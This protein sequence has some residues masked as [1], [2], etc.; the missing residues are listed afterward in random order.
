MIWIRLDTD[1]AE[2]LGAD[3][4]PAH[5]EWIEWGEARRIIR[6]H[7]EREAQVYALRAGVA[8]VVPEPLDVEV[9]VELSKWWPVGPGWRAGF[10]E[11]VI[12]ARSRAE[13]ERLR[14][15]PVVVPE[16]TE[17][18]ALEEAKETHLASDEDP[19]LYASGI[20]HGYKLAVSRL[21]TI[22]PGGVVS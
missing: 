2:I 7:N 10:A 4:H 1:N 16:L 19:Y 14:A 17:S 20:E 21:R 12:W 18:Q 3:E 22:G 13:V 11:G 9:E 15:A 5:G 8:V 6:E